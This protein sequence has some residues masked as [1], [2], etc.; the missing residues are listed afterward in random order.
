MSH[1]STDAYKG[2]RA[3]DFST[4]ELFVKFVENTYGVRFTLD[5]AADEN[6]AKAPVWIDEKADALKQDW[7]GV[8]WLNPP[9]GRNIPTFL[10]RAIEMKYMCEMIVVLIPARTDTKWFHEL[11]VPNANDVLLIKGRLQFIHDSTVKNSCAP[12]PSMLV[13]FRPTLPVWPARITTVEPTLKER[14]N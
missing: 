3:E 13:V 14:G 12:Y 6:N 11:V 4:P 5:A 8:V 10:E 9:Y 2:G 7:R 1:N